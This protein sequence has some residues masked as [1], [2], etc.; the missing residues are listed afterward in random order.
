[1]GPRDYEF[2]SINDVNRSLLAPP[3]LENLDMPVLAIYGS[4]DALVDPNLGSNAYR[5][6]SRINGNPDV[7]VKVF[8]GADHSI[9]TRD[10]EGFLEFAPGYLTMM[11][12]WLAEHR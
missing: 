6:I 3:Q 9:T 5:E 10:G 8:E 2:F 11:G 7:T 12:E 4:E 1:M